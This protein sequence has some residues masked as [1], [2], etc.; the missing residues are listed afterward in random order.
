MVD[1]VSYERQDPAAIRHL[2]T[3]VFTESEGSSEGDLI[4]RLVHDL[5]ATTPPQDLYGYCAVADEHP[6]EARAEEK[7]LVGAIFF[8]RLRRASD[9]TLFLLS[10]VAV[11]PQR[12]G[13]GIGQRLIEHGLHEMMEQGTDGVVTYGDPAFYAKVGFSPLSTEIIPPPFE[14]SQ[15]VGWLGQALAADSFQPVQDPVACVAAFDDPA[16]W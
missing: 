6:Q 14:L 12:Q 5:M 16:L 7:R 2:F 11:H 3:S 4:G 10:P 15:P 1:V 9:Q 8:S 13:E